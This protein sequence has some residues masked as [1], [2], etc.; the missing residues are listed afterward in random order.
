MHI[1][2][3]LRQVKIYGLVDL[4][5]EKTVAAAGTIIHKRDIRDRSPTP[6]LGGAIYFVEFLCN[7]IQV[8]P[9]GG[10][11]ARQNK[12]HKQTNGGAVKR[13]EPKGY[14]AKAVFFWVSSFIGSHINDNAAV[15]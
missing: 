2:S 9:P 12:K 13:S 7:A 15:S 3:R 11:T 10:F 8:L 6:F 4:Q 5:R 1:L 14:F